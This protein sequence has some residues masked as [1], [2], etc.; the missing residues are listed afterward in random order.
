MLTTFCRDDNNNTK[1]YKKPSIIELMKG[2]GFDCYWFS[3]QASKG[4][5]NSTA[6]IFANSC[7][8][9][10]FFQ[11]EGEIGHNINPDI[12]LVDSSYQYILN[13][14][15]HTKHNFIIYHMMGS[16]FDY[17][18]RYTND[19][20]HFS[21]NDYLDY[22]QNQ[23]KILATYDNS[24]L[25]ND[26]VVSRIL[27]IY[28]DEESIIVYIP[29]HGLDMFRSSPDYHAHGKGDNPVSYA[30]G[31]EIPLIIYATPSY[32]EKHFDN[33]ERI[34]YRQNHTK[35]WN[36]ENLPYLL[37]DLIGVEKVN[38]EDVRHKS[39]LNQE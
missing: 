3:N 1:W 5:V 38:G 12:V 27:D 7:E 6:R 24:I 15:I 32:Q 28:K 23:R 14:D 30:Y 13:I 11:K 34:K 18:Q 2:C 17:S 35:V 9:S 10:Y 39:I 20:N 31:V 33:I 37:L 29:D 19:F 8:Q 26:Y 16:H 36:S 4:I 25:Y 21:E 22:P